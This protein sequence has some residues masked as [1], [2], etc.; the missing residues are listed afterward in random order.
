[1]REEPL[2]MDMDMDGAEAPLGPV[3][4]VALQQTLGGVLMAT[5]GDLRRLIHDDSLTIEAVAVAQAYLA[6]K[7]AA[8]E[9][10]VSYESSTVCHQLC[11]GQMHWQPQLGFVCLSRMWTHR[12]LMHTLAS[13]SMQV[14]GLTKR[15]QHH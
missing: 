11:S 8:H 10:Q 12:A 4:A 14:Q 13:S 9:L 2:D 5:L 3:P 1:M 15:L 6:G 7:D